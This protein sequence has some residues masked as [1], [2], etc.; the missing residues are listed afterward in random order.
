MKRDRG[1]VREGDDQVNLREIE[2]LTPLSDKAGVDITV[3]HSDGSERQLAMEEF[4]DLG[5]GKLCDKSTVISWQD[6]RI[7]TLAQSLGCGENQGCPFK[8]K[9][10]DFDKVWVLTYTYWEIEDDDEEEDGM[11]DESGRRELKKKKKKNSITFEDGWNVHGRVVK[12][13]FQPLAQ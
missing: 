2:T 9:K 12:M 7:A 1:G 10:R 4:H 5:S 8:Y 3:M 6:K 11:N 13:H